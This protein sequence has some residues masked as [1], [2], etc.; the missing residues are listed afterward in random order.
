M[1]GGIWGDKPMTALDAFTVSLS[2]M[3]T[4]FIVLISQ[5]RLKKICK[6]MQ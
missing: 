2:G 5:N 4:V 1:S 6:S 3:A